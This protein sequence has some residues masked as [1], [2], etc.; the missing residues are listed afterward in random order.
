M[1]AQKCV[2]FNLSAKIEGIYA[3]KKEENVPLVAIQKPLKKGQEEV[4]K[5]ISVRHVVMHFL[6][7]GESVR[8]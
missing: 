7:Q 2:F 4:Y 8:S 6:H 1:K 3:S 5:D